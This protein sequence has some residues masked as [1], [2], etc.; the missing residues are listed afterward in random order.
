MKKIFQL[1]GGVYF[2]KVTIPVF[3]FVLSTSLGAQGARAS[4]QIKVLSWNIQMLPALIFP[5]T[6][7]MIR[8]KAIGEKLKILNEYDVIVFQEAFKHGAYLE[9]KKALKDLY[10]YQYGPANRRYVTL[11]T[12]SGVM[13]LS[14][15]PAK[16]L[17]EIIFRNSET[18]DD[19]M[20]RKGAMMIEVNKNG[21]IFQVAGTHLNAGGH[22]A[23][24]K[25]QVLDLK[26]LL[27]EFKRPG[28]PQFMAGD[29]NID[30]GSDLYDF[31]VQN[32]AMSDGPLSGPWQF[33]V[34]FVV[35]DYYRF[36]NGGKDQ[37]VIDY[38]FSN[39]NGAGNGNVIRYIP[40]LRV[41]GWFKRFPGLENLSDHLPVVIEAE[42][43]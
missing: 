34:D 41:P 38:I 25:H 4:E 30:K 37:K 39:L 3:L 21:T 18:L 31:T 40:D 9:I 36:F 7:K 1:A 5:K 16:K 6:R 27:D 2:K 20:A 24:R 14:K 11:R 28:V 29:F 12:N 26:R 33:T 17:K 35:N 19:K 8:A 42:V 22:P 10:P 15:Y 43:L 13:I 32:L 23:I